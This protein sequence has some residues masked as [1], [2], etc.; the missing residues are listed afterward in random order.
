MTAAAKMP[1]SCWGRYRRVAVVE[2]SPD[3]DGRPA[4][5]GDRARGVARIVATWERC[6]AGRYAET[7]GRTAYARAYRA[8]LAMA[9]TLNA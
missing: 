7:T 3:F 8:A 6:H 9:A 4:F 1:N 2:L 5:I